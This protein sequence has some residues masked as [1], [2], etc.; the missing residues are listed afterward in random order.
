MDL[1]TYLETEGDEG[2]DRVPT[3][4]DDY[5]GDPDVHV[6]ETAVVVERLAVLRES[7]DGATYE[8]GG[9]LARPAAGDGPAPAVL[10]VHE[11]KGLVPYVRDVVRRLAAHGYVAVAP[12]LLSRVGGTG[13]FADP[14]DLAAALK[15]IPG[16][17]V[18]A[19][20]RAT[21]DHVAA[22]DDVSGDRLGIMGFCYGGG[23][24]WRVLTVEPRLRAGVPFYGPTPDARAVPQIQAPVLAVFGELDERITSQLPAIRELMATHDKAFQALVCQGAPHAFHNDTNPE[25][26][27]PT[28]AREAWRAALGHLDANLR[29]A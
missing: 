8:L 3:G 29:P 28:A 7:P 15:E 12:D 1:R 5:P 27:H 19:D 21:L 14:A 20:V 13:S 6:P 17:D 18:V 22:R 16:D 4:A 11:N 23:V 2:A 25:R 10:V 24:A 9:Y 26:Y